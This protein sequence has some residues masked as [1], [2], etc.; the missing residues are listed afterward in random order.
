MHEGMLVDFRLCRFNGDTEAPM[1]ESTDFD[2]RSLDKRSAHAGSLL[3]HLALAYSPA[4]FECRFR[5]ED[6]VVL[7]LIGRYRFPVNVV[8]MDRSMG[9]EEVDSLVKLIRGRY[10][11]SSWRM[12]SDLQPIESL[13]RTHP[14]RS[15]S[16]VPAWQAG[17]RALVVSDRLERAIEPETLEALRWNDQLQRMQC[18]PL[19]GWSAAQVRAYAERW[20]LPSPASFR[21]RTAALPPETLAVA[22]TA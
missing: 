7:D 13:Q 15:G 3:S 1:T 2:V 20:D 8:V 4:V 9:G 6:L 14:D 18:Q 22:P 11:L 5:A 21:E 17:C 16:I 12:A 10:V 19:A